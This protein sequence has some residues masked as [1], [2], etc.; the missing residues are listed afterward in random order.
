MR[1]L[2]KKL[3]EPRPRFG[4]RIRPGESNGIETKRTRSLAQRAFERLSAF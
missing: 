4:H 1:A 2:G 3:F